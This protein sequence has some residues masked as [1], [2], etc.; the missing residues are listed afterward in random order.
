[1]DTSAEAIVTD[2]LGRRS[3]PRRKYTIGEKRAMVE[4][5]QRR[6]ASVADVAQRRGVNANL[7]FGWRRLY[8]QGVLTEAAP[9][10]QSPLLPVKISTPTL[11]P[12]ERAKAALPANAPTSEPNSGSIEIDFAG[13]VRLRVRGRVDRA[14]LERVMSLLGRR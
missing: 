2:K 5:T 9:A 12:T 1:M 11:V 13:G 10:G 3:G 14:T 7:L 8:R 6:G 4:E